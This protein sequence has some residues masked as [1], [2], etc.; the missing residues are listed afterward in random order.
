MTQI[1]GIDVS[2]WNGTINWYRVKAD[3][4][5]FAFIKATQGTSYAKVAYFKD[6][7]QKAAAAGILVGAYHYGSFGTVAEAQAEANYFL[8]VVSNQPLTYPLVLD[9]E[10]NKKGASR[11]VLTD[12]AIAFLEVVENAGYFALLYSGKNFL[13]TQLEEN[14]LKPYALWV[15]RYGPQLG[16]SADIWQYTSKGSVNGISGNVDLNWAY[17]N[18]TNKP[19][20]AQPQQPPAE[21]QA[22]SIVLYPGYL[23]RNGSRGIDVKRIQRAVKVTADGIFGS[24]TEAAVKAYQ[25]RH[26]LAV[27]GIVG[28]KTWSVMF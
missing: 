20:T 14:R 25:K 15:A 3:G 7:A 16:R 18:F 9:L 23:L 24:K 4:V 17:R 1:K 19:A 8:S 2:H 5:V 22:T 13:E 28:P 27:D 6:N 10:E 12:A 11:A 26:G 21:Q